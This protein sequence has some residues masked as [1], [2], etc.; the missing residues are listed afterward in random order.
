MQL[1]RR[2]PKKFFLILKPLK[3][4]AQ[5]ALAQEVVPTKDIKRGLVHVFR[6]VV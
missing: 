4:V 2:A 6:R 5:E 1:K 3:M